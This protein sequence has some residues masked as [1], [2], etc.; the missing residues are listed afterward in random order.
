M[1]HKLISHSADL[2][3]LR[4]EGYD[5]EIRANHLLIKDVPYVNS[6]REI[7][8]GTLVS[9]LDM[10]GD[11]PTRPSSH[12]AM[13]AGE[14]PCHNDGSEITQIIN[15]RGKQEI[16]KDFSV[17]Y[18]FSSKPNSG[19]YKDYYEK[20]TT[21]VAILSS[22]AAAI[23]PKVTAKTFPVIELKPDESVFNYMDTASSRAGITIVT[24]KLELANVAI[25]GVGGT[26]SYVLDQVAKTPVKAIHIFDGDG[27][28]QHNAFR[29]PGAPTIEE[30]RA[31]P[32]KVSYF[33]A[34][35]SKMHRHIVAHDYN[36]DASNVERLR[37]M[38]F[39][40]LCLDRA[41]P[42]RAIVDKLE[43][44]DVPFV[45]V[46]MGIYLE[47]KSL[48]GILRITTSTHEMR[49]HVREKQRIPFSE[50]DAED[51]YS[52]NIQIADLNALNA[53]LAV[54][55]WKKLFGFYGDLENEHFSAYTIDGNA[56]VNED[57]S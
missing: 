15:S 47:N 14:C 21:Y 3:R 32:K 5:V 42:K 51:E 2:L 19:G 25:V 18:T 10:T 55:K 17:H 50:G 44:F 8:R 22:P 53:Q 28:L 23:D 16:D 38:D 4:Q 7:R 30:L 6:A 54:V 13:F 39:V 34:I 41:G 36:V 29:S 20:M 52:S 40:F 56:L 33:Q 35:Y 37:G 48:Y 26:G 9:V 11:V 31:H 43:E 12:V 46:G 1:S 49:N 27:F 24:Q 45:D 57:Q